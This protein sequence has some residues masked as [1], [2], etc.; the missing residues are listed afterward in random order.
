ML[1]IKIA[2]KA[3][4]KAL[5]CFI[6]VVV[7]VIL[8]T[9]NGLRGTT[10]STSKSSIMSPSSFKTRSDVLSGFGYLLS[11]HFSDQMTSAVPNVASLM[12]VA[13]EWGG[14][15]VVEPFLT[16]ENTFGLDATKEW[17]KELTFSDVYNISIWEQYVASK[18][19]TVSKLTPYE[20]FIED[21]P[22]KVILVQ[23]FYPCGDKSILNLTKIFCETNGFELV[24]KVCLK[25]GAKKKLSLNEFKDQI[26]SHFKPTEVVVLFEW[27]GGFELGEYSVKS[28][29]RLFVDFKRCTRLY[30]P[31]GS[32]PSQQVYSDANTYIQKYLKGNTSYV[33]LMVRVEYLM[34]HNHCF[35]EK[36]VRKCL[37][38]VVKRWREVKQETGF[39]STF[40]AIDVGRYG[41][42]GLKKT[43]KS[44]TA[45]KEPVNDLFS[46]VFNNKTTMEEWEETFTTVGLGQTK[47][48]GY[49]AIMQKVIAVKGDVILLAGSQAGSGYQITAENM[50]HHIHRLSRA[51]HVNPTCQP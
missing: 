39:N 26:Y 10:S 23:Y 48:A 18:K 35:Q 11:M 14:L 43:S 42:T 1:P 2:M 50:Y 3:N 21:A 41:S 20:T 32:E 24:R 46:A 31:G 6:A 30:I 47:S 27:Y 40:L 37:I 8:F 49:I 19:Y 15:R 34:I 22:P 17:R 45:A 25:Y 51:F 33:S 29:W 13:S 16:T 36:C 12:C 28:R 5:Y 4:Y 44:G 7:I 38:D 9:H